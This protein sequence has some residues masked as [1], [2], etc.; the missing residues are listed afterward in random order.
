MIQ[1]KTYYICLLALVLVVWFY[2]TPVFV[3]AIDCEPG[4]MVS[5]CNGEP[6]SDGTAC[7][8]G[9]KYCVWDKDGNY[10][11]NCLIHTN[12]C[13]TQCKAPEN[14]PCKYKPD[15]HW[16]SEVGV[17]ACNASATKWGSSVCTGVCGEFINVGKDCH[18]NE[19][20]GDTGQVLASDPNC[21]ANCCDPTDDWNTDLGR[22]APRG[23]P[24]APAPAPAAGGGSPV[25]PAPA[26]GGTPASGCSSNSDCSSRNTQI[27]IGSETRECKGICDLAN[28]YGDSNGCG[29]DCGTV[30]ASNPLHCGQ[31]GN[32]TPASGG[33]NAPAPANP[34]PA[35]GT[36]NI[37]GRVV[38]KAG[39]PLPNIIINKGQ[40]TTNGQTWQPGNECAIGAATTDNN[41]Y[42]SFANVPVG[43]AFCLRMPQV[44]G[45]N[46]TTP[47]YECQIAGR[48]SGTI[49]CGNGTAVDLAA[50]NAYNFNFTST[51]SP[52]TPT[53]SISL[54]KSSVTAGGTATATV[55][56]YGYNPVKL[57]V[58]R[59]NASA[60]VPALPGVYQK[61]NRTY[62]NVTGCDGS[63][64][65]CSASYQL[66]LPQG[67]Y[68]L[69]CDVAKP[70]G[71]QCSGNPFCTYSN[72]GGNLACNGW[73]HCSA[74][75]NAEFTVGAGSQP[76]T[77]VCKGDFNN[78][79]KVDDTDLVSWDVSFSNQ[80]NKAHCG[81]HG[82]T[83]LRDFHNWW[84]NKP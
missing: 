8:Y 22:C 65:S 33:G 74:S 70:N 9:Y 55:T 11:T 29:Q 41:G 5:S 50:D 36:V 17:C 31:N 38:D 66:N 7:S 26:S 68:Y 71:G 6:C 80:D 76:A 34:A 77:P 20:L 12:N 24:Q 64:Q 18:G 46:Q 82:N 51:G 59:T 47:N 19:V 53:C 32:P 63:S 15:T 75:D 39:K 35:P 16:N 84:T 14:D 56:G 49:K 44:T 30:V 60:I 45:Y 62:Y 52:S 21:R 42:F 1:S 72:K 3:Q 73:K 4:A 57:W 25:A 28:S 54:D 69:H 83:D 58:E 23:A 37:S 81:L 43:R 27:C 67:E 40:N 78:D 61:D 79:G 2:I 13:E 48:N 10:I